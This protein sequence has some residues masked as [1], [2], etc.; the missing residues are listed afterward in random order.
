M[1]HGCGDFAPA[2]RRDHEGL[3]RPFAAC[4]DEI[5]QLY[6]ERFCR[7]WEFYLAACE[8]AFRRRGCMVFQLQ[9]SKRVDGVPLTRGYM[10]EQ[11]HAD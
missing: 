1:G 3:A 8:T 10:S 11:S 5:A 7:M 9:L 4:R 2:L 6:D